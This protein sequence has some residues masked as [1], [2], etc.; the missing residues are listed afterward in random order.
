MTGTLSIL[1]C[2]SFPSLDTLILSDCAVN[3][4]D[5][6]S[7]AQ[8]TVKLRLPQLRHLDIPTTVVLK[9]IGSLYS[10]IDV[11]GRAF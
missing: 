10:A 2:H 3:S 4:D 8:A 1:L 7:L 5:L 6:S 9:W 11:N